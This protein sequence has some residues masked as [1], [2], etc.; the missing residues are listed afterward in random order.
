MHAQHPTDPAF[1]EAI[2][3]IH[4]GEFSKALATL[5]GI[6]IQV[7]GEPDESAVDGRVY[8]YRASA[9]VG[10]GE[11]DRA[12]ASAILSL[13]VDPHVVVDATAFDAKV[14]ALF[15]DV[16]RRFAVNPEAAA[17]NADQ[18]GRR[19]EAFLGY[20]L[21]YQSL[22]DPP[23]A[24]DDQRLREKIVTTA[25]QL[26]ARPVVSQDARAHLQKANDLLTAAAILSSGGS[27]STDQ[28]AAAELRQAVK[29]APWWPDATLGLATVLQKLQQLDEAVVNLNLYKLEDPP[30]YAAYAERTRNAIPGRPSG[31]KT[32]SSS[33]AL[34]IYFP[35][36]SRGFR[37]KLMCDGQRMADLNYGHFIVLTAEPGEHVIQFRDD[38]F[39]TTVAA[40]QDQYVRVGIRGGIVTHFELHE[41]DP[42]TA[43]AE[44]RDKHVTSNDADHTFSDR[45]P[46][47]ASHQER[48]KE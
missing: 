38:S 32:K 19:Q 36:A 2:D 8:V 11:V 20:L 14:V 5:S 40:G 46:G 26:D 25:R 12:D 6:L 10:L 3:Q 23:R 33:A 37:A 35:P 16:R 7:A 39:S 9:Y 21:A 4:A 45:C 1:A 28:A 15:G 24:A 43:D 42:A 18:A 34:H 41:T 29:L 17:Q 47:G 30:G 48:P 13:S 31:P 44:I 22:P 27:T